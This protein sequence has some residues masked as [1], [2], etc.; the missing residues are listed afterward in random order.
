MKRSNK[1]ILEFSSFTSVLLHKYG[2]LRSN[3]RHRQKIFTNV[4]LEKIRSL[5]QESQRFKNSSCHPQTDT[6][7]NIIFMKLDLNYMY[8]PSL[9][10]SL[11]AARKLAYPSDPQTWAG[12]SHVLL[13]GPTMPDWSG[14]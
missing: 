1:Y 5:L 6:T 7:R 2:H 8:I 9:V 10:P 14:G 4:I 13:V 12:G 3:M 11:V